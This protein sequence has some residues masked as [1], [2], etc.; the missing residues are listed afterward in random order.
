MPE[1]LDTP[2][3]VTGPDQNGNTLEPAKKPLSVGVIVALAIFTGGIGV[4]IYLL[5]K[6]RGK[7]AAIVAGVV[8]VLFVIAASSDSSSSSEKT[9]SETTNASAAK[10]DEPAADSNEGSPEDEAANEAAD[11][12]A[13]KEDAAQAAADKRAADKKAAA[14]KAAA[15]KKDAANTI[16]ISAGELIKSFEDNE[17]AADQRFEGKKLKVTGVV[18]KV[19]T[20]LLDSD[21]YLLYFNGGGDFEFLSVSCED[22]P[23]KVL[24]G[25]SKGDNVTIVGKFDDGGDLGVTLKKCK[26]A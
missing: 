5:V 20:D 25:L 8:I 7:A 11:A 4:P 3:P 14:A 19:D 16:A 22:L 26:M 13:A 2:T 21:K 9:K 1:Q 18:D 24:A 6:G 12:A 15:A 23:K 17:L 10:D